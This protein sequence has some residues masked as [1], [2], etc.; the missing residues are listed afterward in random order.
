MTRSPE[1]ALQ[2]AVYNQLRT[3]T[4]LTEALAARKGGLFDNVPDKTKYPRVVIGEG[5]LVDWDTDTSFGAEQT[6]L[7]H[8]WSNHPGQKETK[9]IMGLVY[10]ALHEVEI[11]PVG[12]NSVL[13]RR[14][15]SQNMLDPDGATRHGVLRFRCIMDEVPD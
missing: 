12:F 13:I 3:N 1:Y 5:T 9:E 14:E 10:Q 7:V 8:V 11:T 4:A 2:Q 15:F 6:I